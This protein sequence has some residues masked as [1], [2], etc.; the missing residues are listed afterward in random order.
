M[1]I[2]GGNVFIH[3][4]DKL[5]A[6][7]KRVYI[8]AVIEK[9]LRPVDNSARVEYDTILSEHM[10]HNFLNDYSMMSK[11]LNGAELPLLKVDS[12]EPKFDM[13][14]KFI[15]SG[16]PTD[17]LI[18]PG[19]SPTLF[20]G[21]N[22]TN[23]TRY[24][25]HE[26]LKEFFPTSNGIP[27]RDDICGIM[28]FYSTKAENGEDVYY[29]HT[30]DDLHPSQYPYVCNEPKH[31]PLASSIFHIIIK[32]ADAYKEA[33]ESMYNAL[34]DVQDVLV[35]LTLPQSDG[36]HTLTNFYS[37]LTVATRMVIEFD[38]L[39]EELNKETRFK[40]ATSGG[41]RLPVDLCE[42]D[43]VLC[44]KIDKELSDIK[45]TYTTKGVK[46]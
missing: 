2:Q 33:Y 18:I 42:F 35:M 34:K 1:Q 23:S 29:I 13:D 7:I 41:V 5:Y 8:K 46:K 25:Y 28:N 26:F 20:A 4:G 31:G 27:P 32:H 17:V 45:A 12:A 3:D 21:L 44:R 10:D 39:L 38:R 24:K 9:F 36:N 15:P 40:Y 43:S 14:G 19:N 11:L 6:A 30:F 16:K 22:S 37:I